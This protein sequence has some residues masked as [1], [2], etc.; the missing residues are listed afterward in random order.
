MLLLDGGFDF[1]N[2]YN[3]QE[4]SAFRLIFTQVAYAI[5][6]QSNR[7]TF[8]LKIFDMFEKCTL[9]I[10]YLLSCFYEKVIISKPNTSR[11]ANSEKYIVC[12]FFKYTNS[13]NIS[14]KFIN[15]IKIFETLDFNKY[16]IQSI[17]NFPIQ[18]YYKT[19]L[20]EINSCLSHH[21]MNNILSTIKIITHKDRK[22]D[23]LQTL[24][25]SNIQKCM[26]WCINNNI[27]YNKYFQHSNIFLGDR[28]KNINKF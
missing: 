7:G 28:I 17:L 9:E 27:P 22:N 3:N 11:A 15:I 23:K 25:S 2:D 6:M 18:S 14:N 13:D 20:M 26:N 10:L 4:I 19:Q 24:K 12:K 8:I 21:Q 16:T 1:S 5:T